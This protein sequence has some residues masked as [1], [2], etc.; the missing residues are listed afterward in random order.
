MTNDSRQP[1]VTRATETE[2][3]RYRALRLAALS[4]SAE[5][6][7]SLHSDE[8]GCPEAWWRQRM[9]KAR[10]VTLVATVGGRD[11]GLCKVAPAFHDPATAGLYSMWVAPW[12]RGAAVGD[13]LIRHAIATA[14]SMG[15]SRMHLDVGD[16]N[17]PAIALYARH[18]FTPTGR[19]S[20]LDAPREHITEHE[21]ALDF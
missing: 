7:G 16:D 2:W 12:A 9:V 13:A 5:A 11:A 8:V 20:T 4:E 19:T 1:H 10:H 21:Q 17:A 18:G 15:W 6:F 3:D 14:R